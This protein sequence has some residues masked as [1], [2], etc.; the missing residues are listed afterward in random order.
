MF[1]YIKRNF[2]QITKFCIVGTINASVDFFVYLSLTRLFEFWQARLTLATIAAFIVANLNSYVMNKNWTF[3]NR[4]KEHLQQYSKFLLIGSIGLL[5][6]AILFSL[7]TH[8]C[9]IY[10]IYSKVIVAII[11]LFWNYFTNKYWTFN[12]K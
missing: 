7:F 9:Q 1:L 2:F 12:K 4:D 11:I 10:D 8:Y 6:N 3:K 5:I